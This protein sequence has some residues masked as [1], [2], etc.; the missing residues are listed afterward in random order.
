MTLRTRSTLFQIQSGDIHI[1]IHRVRKY[2]REVING[3]AKMCRTRKWNADGFSHS[4]L[5]R[6]PSEN[7][8]CQSTVCAMVS[9]VMYCMGN[10]NNCLPQLWRP[11]MHRCEAER[12]GLLPVAQHQWMFFLLLLLA[13]HF[14]LVN[15]ESSVDRFGV[16]CPVE[17]N[18]LIGLLIDTYSPPENVTRRV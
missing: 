3:V 6:L 1:S 9:H 7:T 2:V 11:Q 10:N 13:E 15:N 4:S 17:P 8:H 14:S 12:Q 5:L 18:I 16:T